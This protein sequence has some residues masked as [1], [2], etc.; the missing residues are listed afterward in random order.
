MNDNRKRVEAK[1]SNATTFVIHDAILV[2]NT[3]YRDHDSC[4]FIRLNWTRAN[5][6]SKVP[7]AQSALS[8]TG[9]IT[10]P[11]TPMQ[12]S[13][14]SCHKPSIAMCSPRAS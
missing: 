1:E 12:L 11:W 14:A 4:C 3:V 6:H 7:A 13:V 8:Y 9:W 10:P 2:P 5:L